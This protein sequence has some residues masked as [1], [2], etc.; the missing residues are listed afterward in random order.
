MSNKPFNPSTT[1]MRRFSTEELRI[2]RHDSANDATRSYL[3][4]VK[5]GKALADESVE[6]HITPVHKRA[7]R[8]LVE[9]KGERFN[10]LGELT[11]EDDD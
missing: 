11:F 2:I 4:A 8:I 3:K 10:V 7:T 1:E 6:K 9:R 5:E